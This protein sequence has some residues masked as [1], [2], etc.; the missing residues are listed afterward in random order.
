[1]QF[2]LQRSLI[3]KLFLWYHLSFD[4]NRAGI[5]LLCTFLYG[6]SY[7]NTE[8]KCLME[9]EQTLVGIHVKKIQ[10]SDVEGSNI[11]II[12]PVIY[13]DKGCNIKYYNQVCNVIMQY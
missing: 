3:E 12:A 1:L 2:V 11:K 10:H 6:Y 7:N 13:S 5:Q 4:N 8:V 9:Y